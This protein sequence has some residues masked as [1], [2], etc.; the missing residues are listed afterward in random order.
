M[1]NEFIPTKKIMDIFLEDFF[2]GKTEIITKKRV[3]KKAFKTQKEAEKYIENKR[4]AK[5][6]GK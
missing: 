5:G 2:N 3:I 1:W 6:K 4:K